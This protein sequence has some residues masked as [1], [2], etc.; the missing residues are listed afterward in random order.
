MKKVTLLLDQKLSLEV[1]VEEQGK[2]QHPR[3]PT[4]LLFFALALFFTSPTN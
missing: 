1:W 3:P 4:T 2:E